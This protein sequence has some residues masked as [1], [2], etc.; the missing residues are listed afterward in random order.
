MYR[1]T[2]GVVVY[3][4]AT[5][6]KYIKAGMVLIKETKPEIKEEKEIVKESLQVEVKRNE[7]GRTKKRPNK[8]N[9]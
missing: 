6:D 3:D 9:R 5:R 4:E 7:F 2:N 8:F 1:F